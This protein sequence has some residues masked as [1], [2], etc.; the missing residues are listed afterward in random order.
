[1]DLR[2]DIVTG[3]IGFQ[4]ND[5]RA[6]RSTGDLVAQRL[7][8]AL[9]VNREAWFLDTTF[10]VPYLTD[11]FVKNPSLE[12]LTAIFKTAILDTEGVD[13]ITQFDLSL[14]DER[15][16]YLE[17]KVVTPSLEVVAVETEIG[18]DEIIDAQAFVFTVL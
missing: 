1:M 5:L 7:R 6:I 13:E 10:G 9:Q 17:F 12:A 16:L 14:T 15:V 4:A 2:L 3:D 18:T 11:I 8:I